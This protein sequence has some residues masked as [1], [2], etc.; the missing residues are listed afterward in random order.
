MIVVK[1]LPA[2]GG[3]YKSAVTKPSDTYFINTHTSVPQMVHRA[4]T[5]HEV[6]K[7][8]NEDRVVMHTHHLLRQLGL[9]KK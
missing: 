9:E 3:R 5:F 4:E 7:S 6:S 2:H 1:R 8:F